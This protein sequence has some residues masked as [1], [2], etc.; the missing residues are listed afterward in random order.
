[1]RRVAFHTL[2]CKTN[3]YDTEAMA[4]EFRR[5]G[6]RVVSF[7]ERAE[8]YVINTCTVTGR[9]AGKSRQ[10]ARQ[11]RRQRPGALLALTGCYPQ[12]APEEVAALEEV[13]VIAGTG[14]RG[15]IVTLVEE[16]LATGQ[17]VCAVGDIMAQRDFEELPIEAFTERTRATIK[18]QEGCN[19][20]CSYCIIPYARG[21]AR[22]R[23][24]Q[25]VLAE[26]GRLAGAGFKEFVLTGIHLGVY[27]LGLPGGRPHLAELLLELAATYPKVRF[28]LS[29]LEPMEVT[30]QLLQ[31]MADHTNICHHL[32]I[33]LQSG[34]DQILRAMN[35]DYTT[36]DYARRVAQARWFLPDLALTTDVMVG[37]PGETDQ[38]FAR[39]QRFVEEM[40]F[41]QMHI[42]PYSRRPGT[43]AADFPNQVPTRVKGERAAALAEQASRLSARYRRSFLGRVLEVLVE[44]EAGPAH[45]GGDGVSLQG[46][47]GNYLRV[48]FTGPAE[49]VN[50]LVP[51]RLVV[52]AGD[53]LWGELANKD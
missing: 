24:P 29:S 38:E 11:V 51:V 42:F 44:E 16:A 19:Q 25:E 53:Y 7:S 12:V 21:P 34:D 45:L 5:A 39:T 41:S 1:M 43:P 14:Q 4:E 32:H 30:D 50:Q 15:Q 49:L 31:V 20:F 35:R 46:L 3:Q 47:T 13:D 6:Y 28:R 33:P 48:A 36:D 17:R 18:V 22:S 40:A 52:E 37:F 9:G 23:H 2:G 8:V 10:L 26:V 27:G